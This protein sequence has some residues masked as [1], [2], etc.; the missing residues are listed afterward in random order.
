MMMMLLWHYRK[1]IARV[2]SVHVMNAAVP[3]TRQP[4]HQA[5][6]LEPQASL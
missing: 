1:A 2:Y 6:Q 3:S 4:L 5:N